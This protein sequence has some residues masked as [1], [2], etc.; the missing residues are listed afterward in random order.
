MVQFPQW[1]LN[2]EYSTINFNEDL[3]DMTSLDLRKVT[4][5][6]IDDLMHEMN[7]VVE[8]IVY[9]RQ[10]PQE[11]ERSSVDTKYITPKHTF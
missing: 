4:V 5:I 11:H 6:I 9:E 7:E 2:P 3:S 8:K 10:S 1:M